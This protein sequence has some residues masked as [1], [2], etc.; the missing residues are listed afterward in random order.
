MKNVITI[1]L[2]SAILERTSTQV[3]LALLVVAQVLLGWQIAVQLASL[4]EVSG[5]YGILDFEFAYSSQRIATVFD[6]Y[7]EEGMSIYQNIQ[8]L[9]VAN[10]LI[11]SLLGASLMHL[12][13]RGTNRK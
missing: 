8:F 5:G 7:G 13:V 6:N 10:P 2:M 4:E 9:D 12:L 11:Y 1:S 3:G